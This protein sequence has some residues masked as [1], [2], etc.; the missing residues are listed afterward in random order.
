MKRWDF[1]VG[2]GAA[3]AWP[4]VARAQQ[5]KLPIVTDSEPVESR[6]ILLG[7]NAHLRRLKIQIDFNK[8][9]T[10][11]FVA[12]AL[13]NRSIAPGTSPFC[14]SRAPRLLLASA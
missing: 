8:L 1:I 4:V 14:A 11:G 7:V 2:L 9:G 3:A 6:E 5:A 10:D 13:R 12:S